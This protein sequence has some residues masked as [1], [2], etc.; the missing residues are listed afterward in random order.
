MPMITDIT[1]KIIFDDNLSESLNSRKRATPCS[2]KEAFVRDCG[3]LDYFLD[4]MFRVLR[5]GDTPTAN[6]DSAKAKGHKTKIK[7]LLRRQLKTLESNKAA[8]A[9]EKEA[10]RPILSGT[11]IAK[12]YEVKSLV[13]SGGYGVV[14]K[15]WDKELKRFVAIK[16]LRRQSLDCNGDSQRFLQEGRILARLNHPHIVQIYDV[17]MEEGYYYI[18]MEYVKGINLEDHLKASRNTL[19]LSK[20]IPIVTQITGA[21]AAIHSQGIIHR[22]IK[23]SNIM[24]DN[25]GN[26]KLMDFGIAKSKLS[27]VA[28]QSTLTGEG[29]FLGTAEFMAPEQFSNPK[30]VDTSSDVYSLGCT[31][32][33]MAT[34][35]NPIPGKTFLELHKNHLEL[36]PTP[37]RDVLRSVPTSLS[38]VIHKMMSKQ[39]E[40]RYQ[41]GGAVEKALTRLKRKGIPRYVKMFGLFLIVLSTIAI[42]PAVFKPKPGWFPKPRVI[43]VIPFTDQE[44]QYSFVSTEFTKLLKR[45]YNFY[46]TVERG[47]VFEAMEELKLNQ[48]EFISKEDSLRIGKLVGAHIFVMF[49]VRKIADRTVVYPKAFDVETLLLLGVSKIASPVLESYRSDDSKLRL[50]LDEIMES[51]A[52]ELVY[53]S[54]VE[55]VENDSGV[56]LEH[57]R[58]YGAYQGMELRV[59]DRKDKTIG[60]LKVTSADKHTA[61]ATVV[62]DIE[63]IKPGMRVEEIKE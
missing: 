55:R 16:V 44:S 17:G 50:S 26:P 21:L 61:S 8:G 54:Y 28:E 30:K 40:M 49:E 36:E 27:G 3:E 43:A 11:I 63:V 7:R 20:L 4:E 1:Y 51:V 33:K 35:R 22:D 46:N 57:G 37:I 9:C 6:S 62:S 13:G 32:Y 29:C 39:P 38:T 60:M 15:G 10:M 18:I 52:Y 5:T 47:D 41:D 24:I 12:R 25:D 23:P 56:L 48:T 31:F 34:G 58:L 14:Y 53:R 42:L 19:N 45:H 59:L 2:E